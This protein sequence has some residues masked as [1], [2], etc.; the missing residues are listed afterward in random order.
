MRSAKILIMLGIVIFLAGCVPSLHPLFTDKDLV[1]DQC[2][3][4]DLGGRRW[5]EHLDISKI[6]R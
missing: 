5:K 1:F 2:T 6:R 3:C 4:G